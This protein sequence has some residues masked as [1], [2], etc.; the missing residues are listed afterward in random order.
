MRVHREL[1]PGLDEIFYHELL[2]AHLKAAGVEHLFKP[3]QALVHRG[4]T[5]DVFE[6]DIVLPSRLIP[7][8][9]VL[10]TGFAP[11]NY[12][13]LKSYLKFWKIPVGLLFDFGKESL[14]HERFVFTDVPA[15]PV[16]AAAWAQQAPAFVEDAALARALCSCVARIAGEYGLG[17][18]DTTYR[19][20][21]TAD[22]L[23]EGVG[24]VPDPTAIVRS[25]GRPLGEAKLRCLA[26]ENRCAVLVL[27]LRTEIHAADRAILQ[28]CLRHLGFKWGLA[29]HFG[30]KQVEL[31][32]VSAPRSQG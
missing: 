27:A 21:L 15:P 22:L 1:G 8:L 6:P 25:A 20:L 32:W 26:V 5:A 7:E 14:I 4:R 10:W 3:R 31:R 11:E 23:A 13:Q 29:V 30:K 18:R 9:K 19:G 17:Y 28:S 16:D 12:V 2:S 24:C